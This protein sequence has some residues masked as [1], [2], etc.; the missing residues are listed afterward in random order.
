[1][2]ST[3]LNSLIS[4]QNLI[5]WTLNNTH[6]QT[7]QISIH[8]TTLTW[9]DDGVLMLEPVE[10]ALLDVIISCGI[11]G[12][13]TAPIEMLESIFNDILSGEIKLDCR[14]LII[15]GNLPAMRANKRFCEENLNRLFSQQHLKSNT[16]E[17]QRAARIE[18]CVKQFY[19]RDNARRIHLD[20]HTAIRGSQIEKFA[21]YPY[22]ANAEWSLEYLNWLAEADL[23]AVLLGH[24]PSGT[25][26]YYTSATFE[27]MAFTIELGKAL[28]FGQNDHS[29]LTK[30]RRAVVA[31]I[32]NT[33]D[34]QTLDNLKSL[35]I[36]QV[37]DEVL[38]TSEHNFK[39]NLRDDFLNFT[40]LT[41]G[42]TL[43]HDE[44]VSYRI[45]QD[46]HRIVF[47]NKNVPPGQRVALVIEP[48]DLSQIQ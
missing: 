34:W 26:S 40:E 10:S 38:R 24:Q 43:C 48:Y 39:L 20:L 15:L 4:D 12:N 33:T 32:E 9:L 46:G 37:V 22:Q 31:L 41:K 23:Q 6:Q 45:K 29:L 19:T 5:Q 17:A 28:A 18:Q 21:I 47:P 7:S 42:D 14:L 3:A 36:Y 13:E 25:F 2:P 1:M 30:F 11:H 8:D 35:D 44:P 27:A 16:Q